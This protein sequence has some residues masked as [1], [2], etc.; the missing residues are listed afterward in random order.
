MRPK[1]AVLVCEVAPGATGRGLDLSGFENGI[2]L[3]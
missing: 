1:Y 2:D 3:A